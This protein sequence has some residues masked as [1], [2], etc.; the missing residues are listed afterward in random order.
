MYTTPVSLLVRLR[1]PDQQQAWA[2][3]VDLYT[4]LLFGWAR[5]LGL[6]QSDAADLV[7]EVFLVLVR[8]LP[9]FHHRTD[10]RFRG[11]LWTVLTNKHRQRQRRRAGKAWATGEGA[12]DQ[13]ADPAGDTTTEEA[14]YQQYLTRRALELMEADFQ[15]ATWKACWECVVAGRPAAEVAA[16]LGLTVNAVHLAK[17]RVLRRLREELAGLLE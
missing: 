11:W 4:P 7:Q 12:L 8:E 15:P 3:F 5:R 1:T 13:L 9:S 14:E 16:E 10:K 17:A 2:R 6:Q